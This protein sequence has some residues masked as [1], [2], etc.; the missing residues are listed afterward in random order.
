MFSF[1]L[2]PP[3]FVLFIADTKQ[4]LLVAKIG[5]LPS[6]PTPAIYRRA[7]GGTFLKLNATSH[8]KVTFVADGGVMGEG[9]AEA[10]DPEEIVIV[11]RTPGY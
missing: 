10:F 11:L 3:A 2:P 1:D 9:D 7:N 6:M 5:A 4:D 8:V